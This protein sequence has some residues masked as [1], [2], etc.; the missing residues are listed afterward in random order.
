MRLIQPAMTA[1]SA[2]HTEE[3]GGRG[4]RYSQCREEQERQTGDDHQGHPAWSHPHLPD[5][6]LEFCSDQKL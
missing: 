5:Y 2:G 6:I 1:G 3:E 4:E